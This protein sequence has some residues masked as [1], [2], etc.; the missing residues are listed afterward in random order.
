MRQ[1]IISH[2]KI[3]NIYP[4]FR[5][6]K[7]DISAESEK[8]SSGSTMT[9]NNNYN[10]DKPDVYSNVSRTSFGRGRKK[11]VADSPDEDF[12]AGQIRELKNKSGSQSQGSQT[13]TL[14][15]NK[16]DTNPG[17][18]MMMGV[19]NNGECVPTNRLKPRARGRGLRINLQ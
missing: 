8:C 13:K 10:S 1:D 16:G 5:P 11:N 12:I 14:V 17:V 2:F 18:S 4:Y 9:N 3:F 15:S 7:N 6:N 19:A